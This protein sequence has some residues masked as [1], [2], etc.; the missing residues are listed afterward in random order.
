MGVWCADRCWKAETSPAACTNISTGLY[1]MTSR[2]SSFP[3]SLS[4]SVSVCLSVFVWLSVSVS[5]SLCLCLCLSVSLS[6]S[7]CV[8]ACVRARARPHACV[9]VC[10]ISLKLDLLCV[11]QMRRSARK[12][13]SKQTRKKQTLKQI[14]TQECITNPV[15]YISHTL[16]L[17]DDNGK[18]KIY[19]GRTLSG[20]S[21]R[22]WG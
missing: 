5:L 17:H 20:H 6:L 10:V 22:K 13:T 12:L 1:H 9:C 7:L 4:L 19:Y 2:H 3:L 16:T 8:R 14:A 15:N 18:A 11:D 21:A